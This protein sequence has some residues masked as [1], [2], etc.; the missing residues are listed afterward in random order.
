MTSL[1]AMAG[2]EPAMYNA[3]RTRMTYV[4]ADSI[5]RSGQYA[6]MWSLV[7]FKFAEYY[8]R[9]PYLSMTNHI[10][11]DC[12]V[13]RMRGIFTSAY[14]ESMGKGALVESDGHAYDWTTVIRGSTGE[15]LW[16]IACGI[17]RPH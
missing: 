3:D 11:Y 16:K 17:L 14:S 2:W 15:A 8:G 6:R 1:C 9:K 10:E 4:D 13:A 12:Q 7:N 5:R